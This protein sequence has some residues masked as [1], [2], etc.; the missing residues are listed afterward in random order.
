MMYRKS[1]LFLFAAA[2]GMVLVYQAIKLAKQFHPPTTPQVSLPELPALETASA[3]T[4][5]APT[6]HF[7]PVILPKIH[8]PKLAKILPAATEFP[9][10]ERFERDDPRA[11][12]NRAPWERRDKMESEEEEEEEGK[13]YD[14][15]GEAAEYFTRKRAP[16]GMKGVPT[17][18]YAIARQRA[19]QMR[20]YSSQQQ[21]FITS[22]HATPEALAG[23]AWTPLG[24][25]NVGGRTRALLIHP[26]NPNW[27]Y[28]AGTAGGVWRSLDGGQNWLALGDAMANLAVSALAMEPTNANVIYLA[29]A[30]A[31][32]T[33]MLCAA[34]AFSKRRTAG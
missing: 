5:T 26:T 19:Q 31:I 32:S 21:A 3:L 12:R 18:R 33:A 22:G 27:L 11:W 14:K 2:L 1:S 9:A 8:Q 34:Q 7:A 28:A 23:G 15:P 29:R 4:S 30:K 25:G 6:S 13:R 24:P 16:N 20:T 17:E 10:E